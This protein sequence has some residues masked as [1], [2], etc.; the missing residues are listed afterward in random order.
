VKKAL[1]AFVCLSLFVLGCKQEEI[2]APVATEEVAPVAVETAP[3]AVATSTETV[4]T[5]AV[6]QPATGN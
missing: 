3:E 4:V 6:E 1:F 2:A 5:P